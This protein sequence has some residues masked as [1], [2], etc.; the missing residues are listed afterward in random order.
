ME[1]TI[2]AFGTEGAGV[3]AC[4]SLKCCNIY[5]N[6]GG[7]WIGC[8]AGKDTVNGNLCEDPLFCN[9][10]GGDYHLCDASTCAPAQQPECGLIG[11]LGVGCYSSVER[12]EDRGGGV[13]SFEAISP[14]PLATQA[15]IRYNVPAATDLS[16]V[17]IKIYDCRGR[18]IKT[19]V[20]SQKPPGS[21]AAVWNCKDSCDRKVA[22]GVYFCQLTCNGKCLTKRII[23]AR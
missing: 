17:L 2:V 6:A 22:S 20:N 21:H 15:R 14:N 9:L 12:L 23:L 8:L 11:A 13:L 1:N 3:A 10:A 7:D 16:R 4:G 19:V 18:L 5:G